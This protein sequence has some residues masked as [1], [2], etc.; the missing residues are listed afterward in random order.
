MK[1]YTS[2]YRK[3]LKNLSFSLIK[4]TEEL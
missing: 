3:I 1:F 2:I 4:T